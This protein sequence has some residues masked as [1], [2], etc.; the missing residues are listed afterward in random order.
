MT[1]PILDLISEG[2]RRHGSL[3]AFATVVGYSRPALSRRLNG[4]YGDAS[5]LDL[6][7]QTALD[8]R[9][10]PHLGKPIT[11][12]D[13]DAHRARPMPRSHAEALRHWSACRS[14]RHGGAA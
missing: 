10:C 3:A 5:A 2:V 14:C 12:K 6:A 4:S 7:I 9:D 1:D 13:C 11:V 8:R